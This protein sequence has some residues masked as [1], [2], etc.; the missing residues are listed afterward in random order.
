MC[1]DGHSVDNIWHDRGG[2]MA[3]EHVQG[4]LCRRLADGDVVVVQ[5]VQHAVPHKVNEAVRTK[6]KLVQRQQRQPGQGWTL[7]LTWGRAEVVLQER[8]KR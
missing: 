4:R 8:V 6:V 5:K 7:E 1:R 2:D 3:L